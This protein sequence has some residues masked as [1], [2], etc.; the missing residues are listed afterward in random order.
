MLLLKV[1]LWFA[2]AFV[3]LVS[4]FSR[5]CFLDDYWYLLLIDVY[6]YC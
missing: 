4:F 1:S 5:F 2:V 3:Y 6:L